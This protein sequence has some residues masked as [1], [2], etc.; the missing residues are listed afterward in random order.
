MYFN[1]S[2]LLLLLQMNLIKGK[3][4]HNSNR[5]EKSVSEFHETKGI[6][7]Q[8]EEVYNFQKDIE[9]SKKNISDQKVNIKNNRDQ[10]I[11]SKKVNPKFEKKKDK[12]SASL[13]IND[14]ISPTMNE[15][16]RPSCNVSSRYIYLFL[17]RY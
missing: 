8:K 7:L 9:C 16:V 15:A 10:K 17:F 1:Y 14:T 13:K 5:L 4:I 12:V 6:I 11:H 2:V 3:S